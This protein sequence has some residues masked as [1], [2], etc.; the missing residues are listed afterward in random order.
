MQYK[1]ATTVDK[2]PRYPPTQIHR[3]FATFV[4]IIVSMQRRILKNKVQE[5]NVSF[6][7][8]NWLLVAFMQKMHNTQHWPDSL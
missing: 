3:N 1:K 6:G 5:G 2:S 8:C 7:T 4:K